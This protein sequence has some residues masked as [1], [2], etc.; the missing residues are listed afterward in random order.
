[1]NKSAIKRAVDKAG[2]QSALARLIGSGVKQ[3]NV[4]H[5]VQTGVV[6]PKRCWAIEQA[7]GVSRRALR[8]DDWHLLW[9]ELVA[10][11]STQVSE[12]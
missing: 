12:A 1:M 9:P 7:T 6:P 5:W 8:P 3:Q 10:Q 11:G 4:W 2:G